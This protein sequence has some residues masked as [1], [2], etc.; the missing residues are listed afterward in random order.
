[1][2]LCSGFWRR[3][4]AA[5]DRL[6]AEGPARPVSEEQAIAAVTQRNAARIEAARIE[7]SEGADA[8]VMII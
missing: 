2:A 6:R 1:M 4:V 3:V 7:D 5:Q 8:V